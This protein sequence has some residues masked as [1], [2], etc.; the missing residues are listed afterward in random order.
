MRELQMLIHIWKA[1]DIAPL[2]LPYLPFTRIYVAKLAKR[3]GCLRG[4]KSWRLPLR[5][6]G[7]YRAPNLR[8]GDKLPEESP[9]VCCGQGV[10]LR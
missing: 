1:G 3:F 8:S 6:A 7:R 9:S 5:L 10:M 4:R 2:L